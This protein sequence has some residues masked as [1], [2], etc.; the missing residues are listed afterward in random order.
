MLLE[1]R[2]FIQPDI[3][4][5]S[6]PDAN[7]IGYKILSSIHKII[8]QDAK[9][10]L[11]VLRRNSNIELEE[12]VLPIYTDRCLPSF[13]EIENLDLQ[14]RRCIILNILEIDQ[15]YS[16]IFEKVP[17]EWHLFLLS[18]K[19]CF[20]STKLKLSFIYSL[21]LCFVILNY[22]DSK[23]NGFFRTYEDLSKFRFVYKTSELRAS[24]V[25]N[26]GNIFSRISQMDCWK[27][28]C[29]IYKHFSV[30]TEDTATTFNRSI[31]HSLAEFKCVF[32]HL[33]FLNVLLNCP[34]K[35]TGLSNIFNG[36]FIYNMSKHLLEFE[37]DLRNFFN[38][39]LQDYASIRCVIF[40]VIGLLRPY[41]NIF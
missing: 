3:E 41:Y 2:Y 11:T 36:T 25:S 40:Y 21:I 6:K 13:E 26:T 15:A 12:Y 16:E 19:Y 34:F 1:D 33:K 7:I 31:M 23:M 28:M 29:N 32:V 24:D 5:C 20:S 8:V 4:D 38:S 10:G 35:D 27:L 37:S 18:L 22:V 14:K 30:S 9:K 17:N 39:F